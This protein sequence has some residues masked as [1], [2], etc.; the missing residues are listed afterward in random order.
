MLYNKDVKQHAEDGSD[1]FFFVD[2]K[3]EIKNIPARQVYLFKKPNETVQI[4][5]FGHF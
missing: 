1:R 3:F 5:V 4:F 2:Y